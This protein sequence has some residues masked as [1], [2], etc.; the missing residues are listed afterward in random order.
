MIGFR[1][2][3]QSLAILN[4]Y[5]KDNN[6][7]KKS[8]AVNQIIE[9]K[10]I[11]VEATTETNTPKENPEQIDY[12]TYYTDCSF[13]TYYPKKKLVHCACHWKS[14]SSKK[15]GWLPQDRM[16]T[17]EECD[18]CFPRVQAFQERLDKQNEERNQAGKIVEG[19]P[20][21]KG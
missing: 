16:V 17:P 4:Q 5:M 19:G 20:I 8:L 7:K 1:P 11:I 9:S 10:G 3:V 2:S 14:H 18:R 12:E 13:G 6:I 21:F 15:G